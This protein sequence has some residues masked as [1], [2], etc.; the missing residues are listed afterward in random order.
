MPES[1]RKAHW[2]TI[3]QNKLPTD[4]SWFQPKPTHSLALI[5]R[6][7]SDPAAHIVDIGSGATTLIAGLLD[8]GY[9]NI[10]AIDIAASALTT[11]QTQLGARAAQV[12]WIEAD[13]T[14]LDLPANSVDV[15]HDR[16]VFHF[17]TRT[18]DR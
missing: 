13:V 3:Y 11:A 9:T 17:L 14:Q 6:S 1:A 16:A 18:C 7:T 8:A 4:V 12:R 5:Q 10:R 15:W 2:E